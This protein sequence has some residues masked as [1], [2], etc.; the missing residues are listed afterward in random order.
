MHLAK[1]IAINSHF[2]EIRI[3]RRRI[4]SRFTGIIIDHQDRHIV[5]ITKFPDQ[6]TKISFL[7]LSVR[8][9]LLPHGL[10][11]AD[12]VLS[13]GLNLRIDC[14]IGLIERCDFF[15]DIIL[16]Q[17]PVVHAPDSHHQDCHQNNVC[18][19]QSGTQRLHHAS[20]S[21]L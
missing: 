6:T 3:S 9:L 17:I 20:T 5:Y 21:N 15:T 4:Q 2:Q 12:S 19:G 13:I 14:L 1:D 11:N 16:F 18:H 7:D 8:I 10:C